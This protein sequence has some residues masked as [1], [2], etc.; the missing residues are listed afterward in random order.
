MNKRTKITMAY[1]MVGALSGFGG[2]FLDPNKYTVLV[3][4][5]VIVSFSASIIGWIRM[6][7]DWRKKK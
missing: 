3:I 5:T 4:F 1:F 2:S 6:I 7:S